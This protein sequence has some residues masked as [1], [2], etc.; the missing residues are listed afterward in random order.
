MKFGHYGSWSMV[1]RSLVEHSQ[2]REALEADQ[3]AARVA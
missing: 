2:E 3:E 1:V